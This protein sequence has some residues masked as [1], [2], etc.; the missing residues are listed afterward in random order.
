MRNSGRHILALLEN[1]LEYSGL[2]QG[3]LQAVMEPFNVR[4]LF[5]ETSD[6]LKP[7]TLRKNLHLEY[8][9]RIGNEVRLVSDP[10]KIRQIVMNLLSN[11]VKYT[12]QGGIRFTAAYRAG[13]LEF[14][15]A[16]TGAG[17]P[18]E[19]LAKLYEPFT[20]S[21]ENSHYA[22]GT[23]LGMFVVKGLV[24][25]LNG[26]VD[27]WSEVGK[28]TAVEV[29]IPAGKAEETDAAAVSG[30]APQHIILVD[31]DP[32]ILLLLED[33]LRR[34]GHDVTPC[35]TWTEFERALF[36]DTLYDAILTDMEMG[37]F[38]GGSVLARTRDAG[39]SV[40]VIVMTG[41]RSP[42]LQRREWDSLPSKG[43]S[44][45][46]GR[47]SKRYWRVSGQPL[48]RIWQRLRGR[49]RSRISGG[50]RR[51]ATRCSPCFFR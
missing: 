3:T 37:T 21:V 26:T 41:R 28:G 19:F 24:E 43:C 31:D 35:N 2:E 23:G 45:V 25:L 33:M 18:A 38:S 39:F 51:Y 48:G 29:K 42:L 14:C 32:S 9:V 47:L 49:R 13:M 8:D 6:M 46:T 30:Q 5:L 36:A 34:L 40:P 17:I 7:L 10:L 16:D 44:A 15:V 11:A 1:L 20:R 22:E 27:I 50:R 12:P 4:E